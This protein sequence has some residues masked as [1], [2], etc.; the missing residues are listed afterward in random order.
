[1]QKPPKLSTFERGFPEAGAPYPVGPNDSKVE[2]IAKVGWDQRR[3][4]APAHQQFS[5][6]PYGG[7]ALEASWSHP[8]EEQLVASNVK[9][10]DPECF[11]ETQEVE[12][13]RPKWASS[14]PSQGPSALEIEV[15]TG[16]EA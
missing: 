5:K 16:S 8:R 12:V 9:S 13:L 3:F 7:S 1:M 11:S 4:A 15:I 2:H 14:S 6:F 10:V